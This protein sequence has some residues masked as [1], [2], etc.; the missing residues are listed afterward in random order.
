[1]SSTRSIQ[2][3]T[4]KSSKHCGFCKETGHKV[5]DCI[6]LA[7]NECNYCHQ[8]GHT[9]RR[10]PILADK[11]HNRR[12]TFLANRRIDTIDE[13]GW[14]K[15]K[16]TGFRKNMT[17]RRHREIANLSS[18]AA[19]NSDDEF[20]PMTTQS[21]AYNI[22]TF[23]EAKSAKGVWSKPLKVQK[24]ASKPVQKTALKPVQK[25][26]SKPVQKTASKPVQKT[27][28]KPVQ[29]KV[30]IFN[31]TPNPPG[32]RWADICDTDDEEEE[33]EKK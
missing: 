18:F 28:S 24:T 17:P 19:L 25:T 11:N 10:C 9:T 6:V 21:V 27:A 1:M 7:N 8:L 12:Q 13:N 16:T 3:H 22:P 4:K 29:K 23:S 15:A 30:S 33:Q 20:E 2:F 32:T 14:S 31:R 26:A 5:K